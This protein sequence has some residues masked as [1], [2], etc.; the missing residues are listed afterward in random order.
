MLLLFIVIGAN[1]FYYYFFFKTLKDI[2]NRRN[3]VCLFYFTVVNASP[4]TGWSIG[5]TKAASCKLPVHAYFTNV[6]QVQCAQHCFSHTGCTAY[7]FRLT[8][9]RSGN[10]QL[11]VPRS[12]A[13]HSIPDVAEPDWKCYIAAPQMD[14]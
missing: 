2:L 10:C 7:K 14:G 11:L 6:Q 3:N 1:P 12:A 13:S 9:G 8:V 4:T 5:R